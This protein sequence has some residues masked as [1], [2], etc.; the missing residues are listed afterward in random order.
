MEDC[1]A[2]VLFSDPFPKICLVQESQKS[3][4]VS[5]KFEVGSW[6]E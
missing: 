4:G 3:A 6:F 2:D 5:I 1:L